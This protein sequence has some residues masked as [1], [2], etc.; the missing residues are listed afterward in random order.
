MIN[1][2]GAGPIGSYLAY[3]LAKRGEEVQLF[4]EHAEIGKLVQCAATFTSVL[5]DIIPLK[6]DLII[7]KI[8]RMRLISPNNDFLDVNLKK[9][10]FVLD[11]SEFDKY[12]VNMA[13]DSGVK[14]FLGH[15]LLDINENELIFKNKKIKRDILIGA[16]G[17]LSLVARKSGL[18]SERVFLKGMQAR[19]ESNFDRD[20]AL[21]HLNIG[22]FSWIIPENE[23]I[24]RVGVVCRNNSQE[25]FKKIYDKIEGRKKI[26]EYQGGLIPLY[27][28]S[29][30]I[31]KDGN[32]FLIGDA[33]GMVKP[34]TYGGI[35]PGL[36]AAN[37][38]AKNFDNYEKEYKKNIEKDLK[39]G[40]LIRNTLNK[41]SDED[42]NS[43]INLFKQEKLKRILE[44][45]D[46]DFPSK[47]LFKL[48]LREPRLLKFALRYKETFIYK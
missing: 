36:L 15:K 25:Y 9:E 8:K 12:L 39:P 17:P 16:D 18:L 37:I 29:A 46:R 38:L 1:I 24:A 43:L 42:Y 5:S 4:E 3:L 35:I 22:E 32:T 41:F 23:N 19:V 2:I 10:N 48:L 31:S 33:A 44:K 27:D 13:V 11:R 45:Y 47:F 28:S 6:K 7:N 14:L 34:T 26:I 30:K 40:L 21:T 20:A